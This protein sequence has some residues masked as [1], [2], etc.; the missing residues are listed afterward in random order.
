MTLFSLY[1][2]NGFILF[3]ER[4]F[5]YGGKNIGSW[6]YKLDELAKGKPKVLR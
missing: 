2:G 5:E 1:E 6:S 3:D 4:R